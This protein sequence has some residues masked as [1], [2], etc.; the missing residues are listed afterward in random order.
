MKT[1]ISL[2]DALFAEADRLAR[3]LAKSRSQ[4]YR[5]AVE[6][7]IARHDPEEVTRALDREPSPWDA[8]LLCVGADPRSGNDLDRL[9]AEVRRRLEACARALRG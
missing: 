1:A 4:L 6:E 3:R 5:E 8:I 9:E 2:P 7:Y